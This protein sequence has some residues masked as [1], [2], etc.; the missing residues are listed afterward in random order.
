MKR[1]LTPLTFI[2][3]CLMP[4]MA[5][6]ENDNDYIQ[7]DWYPLLTDS[8]GWNITS[9]GFAFGMVNAIGKQAPDV[10]MASS[11]ELS[12]I[13]VIGAKYNNGKGQRVT[14]GVGID[15]KNYKL[16]HGHC[17]MRDDN[18]V[19]TVNDYPQNATKCYSRIKVFS[20]G[21][22]IIFRQRIGKSFDLF[23]GEITNFNVHASMYTRYRLNDEKMV[24][25]SSKIHQTPVSIDLITG[26]K[27]KK[28]GFYFR[29]NPFKV[30]KSDYAPAF[31]TIA[32]GIV[33]CL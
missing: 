30:I 4:L 12:W 16:H 7:V 24:F 19:I 17:F 23:L 1:L 20:L 3:C 22:P 15:W 21:L 32:T 10:A 33:L 11:F 2:L 14:I 13:N 28:L 26:L 27:Y 18:Q 5:M 25:K 31:S 9:G 8:V 6:A 29:Y